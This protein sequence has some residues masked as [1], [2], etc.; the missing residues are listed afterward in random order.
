MSTFRSVWQDVGGFD[1]TFVGTSVFEEPDFSARVRR[2]G[3]RLVFTNATT[4][5][6][7]PQPEGND[8]LKCRTPSDYYRS[9][10][11]NE[12]IYF[13]KNHSRLNLLLVIPFCLL[14]TVNQTVKFRMG[15]RQSLRVFGGVFEGFRKYYQIYG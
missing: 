9:F 8:D 4:V 6:H 2:A 1:T 12:L 7:D 10:H 13:L 3:W 11:H 14:R 5:R 15:F